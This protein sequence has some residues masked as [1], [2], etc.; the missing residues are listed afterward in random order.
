MYKT[1]DGTKQDDEKAEEY[2]SKSE[3]QGFSVDLLLLNL[4]IDR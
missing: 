4:G 2:F 1:G 3:E